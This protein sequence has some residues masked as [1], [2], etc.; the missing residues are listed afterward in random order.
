ML[1]C[2]SSARLDGRGVRSGATTSNGVR[3]SCGGHPF[4]GRAG[5]IRRLGCGPPEEPALPVRGA[6]GESGDPVFLGFDALRKHHGSGALGVRGDGAHHPGGVLVGSLTDEGHVELD[7][8]R[9]QQRQ[10]GQ[11]GRIGAQ[12]VQRD[13]VSQ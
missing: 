7:H 3:A 6:E 8:I 12:V 11:R 2:T 9:L 10:Q 1:I 13:A 4:L 5:R